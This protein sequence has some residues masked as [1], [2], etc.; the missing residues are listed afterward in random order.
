MPDA[1]PRSERSWREAFAFS[2]PVRV[3]WS[4]VDM[5][6]VVFNPN[7]L[8]FADHAMTD[9]LA[10]LGFPYPDALLPLGADVFAASSAIDFRAPA[11]FGDELD[12]G[13]RVERIGRTSFRMRFAFF[14]GDD[15]VCEA[16]TTYVCTTPG[17]DGK[18]IPVPAAFAA[19]VEAA[20]TT[21]PERA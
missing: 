2:I 12:V 4:D 17:P 8:V 13:A 14:R 6:G 20:E 11:R 5:Q 21:P 7:Y 18:P 9:Y 1:A 3:R 15:L 16:A 10:H 19:A